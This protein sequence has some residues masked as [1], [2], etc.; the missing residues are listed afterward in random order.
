MAHAKT[1]NSV[2]NRFPNQDYLYCIRFCG[3]FL[4]NYHGIQKNAHDVWLKVNEH[5]IKWAANLVR[6]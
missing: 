5:N 1:H 4:A 3:V 2:L 6:S